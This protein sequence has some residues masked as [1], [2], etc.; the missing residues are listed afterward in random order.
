MSDMTSDLQPKI[1]FLRGV[2]EK[3]RL[4]ILLALREGEKT[5]N[6]ITA[7]TGGTQSNISQHLAC[8]KG[9]GVISR[10]Q[11]GKYCYYALS[12]PHM[13][14]FLNMLDVLMDEIG[15]DVACCGLNASLVPGETDE[16]KA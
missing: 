11:E 16:Q 1:K 12:G 13:L 6:D 14:D 7:L 4:S 2:A 15:S 8:L 3:T 9:C 10:R 5:V